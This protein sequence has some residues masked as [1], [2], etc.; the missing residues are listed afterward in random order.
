MIKLMLNTHKFNNY[1][2]FCPVSR[3]HL[4]VSNPVGYANEVTP[5][6]LRAVKAKTVLDVDGVIDLE[7]GTVKNSEAAVQKQEA[8]ASAP[9]KPQEAPELKNSEPEAKNE[10]KENS[11]PEAPANP[12]VPVEPKADPEATS[13]PETTEAS[14]ASET[15]EHAA[16]PA[17]N[18][19]EEKQKKGG[20]KKA[21]AE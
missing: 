12:E 17:E 3:L 5:V 8:P 20:R 11:E 4:T 2:F 14:T 7:T 15:V 13:K 21:D 1:A 10:N 16:E 18:G 6:I 9:Q 19:T